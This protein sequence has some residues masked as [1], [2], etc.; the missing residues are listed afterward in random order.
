MNTTFGRGY[1]EPP[2]GVT[3]SSWGECCDR[4]AQTAW[5]RGIA[6]D[7]F[8]PLYFWLGDYHPHADES[9]GLIEFQD[10]N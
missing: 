9:D 4:I 10:F 1:P 3:R 2:E 6:P 7:Y 5:T 8:A